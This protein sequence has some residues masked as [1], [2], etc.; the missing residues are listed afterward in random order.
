[1]TLDSRP[2]TRL[3]PTYKLVRKGGG[4]QMIEVQSTSTPNDQ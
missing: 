2:V 3:E 4:C 1:M